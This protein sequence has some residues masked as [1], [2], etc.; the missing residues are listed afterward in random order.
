[1]HLGGQMTLEHIIDNN[2]LIIWHRWRQKSLSHL[3]DLKNWGSENKCLSNISTLILEY[4]VEFQFTT[5]CLFL[6]LLYLW[7]HN[8][9]YYQTYTVNI[10][11]HMV[12]EASHSMSYNR[13]LFCNHPIMGNQKGRGYSTRSSMWAFPP[14]IYS[15]SAVFM[16]RELVQVQE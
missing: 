5:A 15:N 9:N 12:R 3:A 10:R 8:P 7:S 16:A 1:M 2:S 13:F 14:S 6:H 4:Y 11:F